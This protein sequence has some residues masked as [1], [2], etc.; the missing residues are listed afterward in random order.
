[1]VN[2]HGEVACHH[3]DTIGSLKDVYT[4]MRESLEDSETIEHCLE[5]GLMEEFG[6]KATL[7]RLLGPIVSRFTTQNTVI[8]K[9]TLYFFMRCRS[10]DPALRRLDDPES[11]SVICFI[12]PAQLAAK[13]RDQ[14]KRYPDRTDIDESSILD[15]LNS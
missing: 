15:R 6:A 4:L 12:E 14:A 2:E 1:M 5:R 3:F 9:T 10:I 11:D 13:M 8:E 7:E